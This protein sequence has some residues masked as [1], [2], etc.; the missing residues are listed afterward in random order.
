MRGLFLSDGMYCDLN[1]G[2][3]SEWWS[4]KG[5]CSKLQDPHNRLVFGWGLTV[6]R[7]DRDDH[8]RYD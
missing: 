7:T 3:V 6:V 5:H 4:E 2:F 1:E 8:G